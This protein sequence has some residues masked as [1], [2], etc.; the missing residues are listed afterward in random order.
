MVEIVTPE[1]FIGGNNTNT[2]VS[3]SIIRPKEF[4]LDI[5][6]L[7]KIRASLRKKSIQSPVFNSVDFSENF[8]QMLWKMW[9]VFKK[10]L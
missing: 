3:N 5:N 2:G 1:E 9:K 10:E 4:S 6:Q 7:S 8:N